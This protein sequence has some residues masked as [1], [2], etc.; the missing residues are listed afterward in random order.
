M[1]SSPPLLLWLGT[2][3]RPASYYTLWVTTKDGLIKKTRL[4]FNKKG[5]DKQAI[6]MCGASAPY[7]WL[8]L[9]VTRD[10]MGHSHKSCDPKNAHLFHRNAQ[11][12]GLYNSMEASSYCVW[13]ACASTSLGQCM[14]EAP[15]ETTLVG[16][17]VLAIKSFVT[18][19]L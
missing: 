4:F 19:L 2:V 10:T 13:V 15:V 6:S 3:L 5:R 9:R 11:A 18:T 12:V 8:G 14:H 7:P 17:R 16:Q 1:T